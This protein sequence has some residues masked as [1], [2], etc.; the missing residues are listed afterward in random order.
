MEELAAYL[1]LDRRRALS[2]GVN[3]DNKRVGVVLF[4]DIS[5]FSQLTTEFLQALGTRRVSEALTQELNRVYTTVIDQIHR[6]DGSVLNF[7]GDAIMCWFDSDSGLRGLTS[8]QAIQSMMATMPPIVT[9]SGVQ[10]EIGIK[11]ALAK[12]TVQRFLVGASEHGVIEVMAGRV[13]DH[14]ALAEKVAE[15]GEIVLDEVL[16][17]RYWSQ[18]E[19]DNWR[20][21][22]GERFGRLVALYRSAEPSNHRRYQPLAAEV[23][24]PW[25]L[26]PVFTRLQQGQ[27]EFLTELRQATALFIRFGQQDYDDDPHAPKRLDAFIQRAQRIVSRYDGYILQLTTGDKGSYLYCTFGAP[28]AHEDDPQRAVGAALEL[29][30]LSA[31]FPFIGNPQIGI[32]HGLART[33]AYGS[34][35]R[36]TYGVLGKEVNVA[37]QLMGRAQPGQILV[38]DPIV[39][40]TETAFAY[41]NLEPIWVKGRAQPL[42]IFA[43]SGPIVESAAYTVDQIVGRH[44]ER[45]T[46]EAQINALMNGKG[47]T[48]MIEGEAGIGKSYLTASVASYVDSKQ[49]TSMLGEASAVEQSS[50][51]FAWRV[52][53]QGLFGVGED[54]KALMRQ[55]VLTRLQQWV[56][57]WVQYAPLLNVVLPIDLPDNSVT[58][59]MQ[60]EVRANNISELFVR[61]LQA[62][63]HIKPLF[64]IIEDAHW[65]DSASWNLLRLAQRDVN[66]L[67]LLIVMR[68]L[69]VPQPTA[70]QQLVSA[71][72][73]FRLAL[74][75]LPTDDIR[76]LLCHSL[77][78]DQIPEALFQ[79]VQRQA[80]GHPFF[81]KEIVFALRDAGILTIEQNICR[82]TH[83]SDKLTGIAVPDTIEGV[84][85]SRIDRLAPRQQLMLKVA[86]VIGRVFAYQTLRDVHPVE[87]NQVRLQQHLQQVVDL[88]ITR[89][90][91]EEPDFQ[92]L[93]KHIIT[94]EVIYNL[95]TFAQRR[96]LHF[97]VADWFEQQFKDDLSRHY[98]LLV[99]HWSRAEEPSKTIHY[100]ELAGEQALE[101]NASLEAVQFYSQA[102][103]LA[104]AAN[105]T[106]DSIQ[107]V[108][109][110]GKLG[111]AHYRL[112]NMHQ[113]SQF[114]EAALALL[115]E[116]MPTSDAALR[117]S[118]LHQVYVQ[119]RHRLFRGRLIKRVTGVER[120][121]LAIAMEIMSVLIPLYFIM[122]KPNEFLFAT[123]ASLNW[124]EQ[125]D[126]REALAGGYAVVGIIAGLICDKWAWFY[127]EHAVAIASQINTPAVLGLTYSRRGIYKVVVGQQDEAYEDY[128]RAMES[129]RLINDQRGVGDVH[130]YLMRAKW[131]GG[132]IQ[133]AL[134]H[135]RTL[136]QLGRK[137]ENKQH[138]GW[139]LVYEGM[140]YLRLR[141]FEQVKACVQ[142]AFEVMGVQIGGAE[143]MELRA[144]LAVAHAG[145]GDLAY[146]LQ[147]ADEAHALLRSS[148]PVIPG[149]ISVFGVLAQ[150]YF[151]CL[152]LASNS[153]E[154]PRIL[155]EI[156]SILRLLRSFT[157]FFPSA[158][159]TMSYWDGHYQWQIGEQTR[160]FRR[161]RAICKQPRT[162]ST[163]YLVGLSHYALGLYLPS[164]HTERLQHARHAVQ[165][166]DLTD[167][168]PDQT[169]ARQLLAELTNQSMG[170][171]Q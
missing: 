99:Y 166:L 38:T 44:A 65:L 51:Y 17:R 162:E 168:L 74:K 123:L 116:P 2:D 26:P 136:S 91:G 97:A 164:E 61:I 81:S 171:A 92:Y 120:T 135:S 167:V 143:A 108:G 157:R 34:P 142:E 102:I 129:Y 14:M 155:Q 18:I 156:H 122:D 95:N 160:A 165:L 68:P 11:V 66:P 131:S 76:T 48:I 52:I 46:I 36:R 161:W 130:N 84:I 145:S 5:G 86:S 94:Q 127:L 77:E 78:V 31:E 153:A 114:C 140:C 60:G 150:A 107:Y 124:A 24:R 10:I 88:D 43:V 117:R 79:L 30:A 39:N 101:N 6:F 109:W 90:E 16:A 8:A 35:H 23:S 144:M 37:A 126:E 63:A 42:P 134:H 115:G 151:E 119:I 170:D 112:G 47:H 96:S 138:A 113:C 45:A 40:A 3:L 53:F 158:S 100:L 106:T 72:N 4:A 152:S 111:L 54:N 49:V 93:F 57:D 59:Y 147:A 12:G 13:L 50:A 89:M 137:M 104:E 163:T 110:L 149:K 83:G 105:V 20:V 159:S 85:I 62:N 58:G 128:E 1:P 133:T 15:R 118:L 80:E 28:I 169:R 154:R 27:G 141:Q 87:R 75:P 64:L 21:N 125:V 33:G 103:D 22:G 29:Q 19:V 7:S 148:S 71:E 67:L 121:R 70:Y 139:G 25:L 41:E 146:A 82:L 9:P 69:P 132:K 73:A 56:P 32:S 98:P 55:R